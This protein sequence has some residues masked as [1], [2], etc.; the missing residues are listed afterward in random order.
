MS[1]VQAH[2]LIVL[3]R[4]SA[5]TDLAMIGDQLHRQEVAAFQLR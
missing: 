5:E 3:G 2:R 1:P 4:F